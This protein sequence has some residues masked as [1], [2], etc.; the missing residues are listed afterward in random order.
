[1]VGGLIAALLIALLITAIAALI[2]RR[3]GPWGTAWTFFLFLFLALW[4]VS[5]Y[6]K[7]VGPV[8]WGIAW[9]PL[10]FAAV[11]IALL[12]VSIIPDANHW[13]DES[14]SESKTNQGS[15]VKEIRDVSRAHSGGF[16]LMIIILIIAIVLGMANPQMAL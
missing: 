8:Y 13:R 5:I 14:L 2:F 6:I 4:T 7:T 15:S 16:W 3:R 9:L 10:L 12:L 1:M 11:V